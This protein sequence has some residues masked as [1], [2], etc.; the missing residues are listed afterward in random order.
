MPTARRN[1]RVPDGLIWGCVALAVMLHVAFI[2]AFIGKGLSLG[3][4]EGFSHDSTGT[5]A[6]AD[7]DIELQTTC[8][9]DV[10]LATSARAVM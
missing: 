4:G 1:R 3:I 5:L 9:G 7:P 2:A 10:L 8:S 6:E